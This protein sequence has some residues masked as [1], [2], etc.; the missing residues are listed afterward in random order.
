MQSSGKQGAR[1]K[2]PNKDSPRHLI[3]SNDGNNHNI[4][5]TNQDD[6]KTITR[7]HPSTR[8]ATSK[9]HSAYGTEKGSTHRFIVTNNDEEYGF[10]SVIRNNDNTN[11]QTHELERTTISEPSN[12]PQGQWKS[13]QPHKIENTLDKYRTPQGT[14]PINRAHTSNIHKPSSWNNRRLPQ[15][16]RQPKVKKQDLRTEDTTFSDPQTWPTR[17]YH[18][19]DVAKNNEYKALFGEQASEILSRY[20][21]R[22]D[23]VHTSEGEIKKN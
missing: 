4:A 13:K 21:H 16:T 22:H 9:I 18:T 1:T 6:Y 11:T 8:T 10:V 3:S 12:D 5:T 19:P 23:H 2:T 20:E 14:I 15:I 7:G 17:T